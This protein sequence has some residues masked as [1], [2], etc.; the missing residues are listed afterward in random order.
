[1]E[2]H[3]F[4]TVKTSDFIFGDSSSFKHLKFDAHLIWSF[5]IFNPPFL[6]LA[7]GAWAQLRVTVKDL[8]VDIGFYSRL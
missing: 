1:M 7:G 8:W 3:K 4:E 5:V 2:Q 6:S